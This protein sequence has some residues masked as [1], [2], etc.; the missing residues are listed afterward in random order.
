MDEA[1]LDTGLKQVKKGGRLF[2]AVQGLKDAGVEVS[3]GEQ[4]IPE[5]SRLRG[6]HI[7]EMRDI[8]VVENFEEVKEKIEGES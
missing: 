8:N 5:E 2:A 4:M 6:E 7:E 3:V 1:V